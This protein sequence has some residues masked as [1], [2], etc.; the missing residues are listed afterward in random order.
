MVPS[1]V[2]GAI[3]D[4]SDANVGGTAIAVVQMHSVVHGVYSDDVVDSILLQ[5]LMC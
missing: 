3:G 1:F 2:V 4:Y 5:L